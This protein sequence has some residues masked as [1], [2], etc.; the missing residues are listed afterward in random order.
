LGL[1]GT[2]QSDVCSTIA[3]VSCVD[4]AVATAQDRIRC[5]RMYVER[6]R[7]TK[8]GRL[9]EVIDGNG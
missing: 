8:I 1:T 9:W 2:S 7:K 4:I 6:E 3:D 5:V